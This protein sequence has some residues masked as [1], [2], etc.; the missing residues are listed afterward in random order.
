MTVRIVDGILVALRVFVRRT[1][2]VW[3]RNMIPVAEAIQLDPST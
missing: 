1:S 3:S 2:L